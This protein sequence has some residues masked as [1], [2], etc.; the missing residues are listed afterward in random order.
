M[1]FRDDNAE[2]EAWLR[3]QCQVV[4]DDLAYKHE[5]MKKSAFIFLRATYFRWARCIET[6]CPA[7]KAAPRVLSVGD[8]HT[9]NY[10][11]WRDLEGRLV[12]GINDFDEAAIMP[13]PFDLVRLATSARLAE[14]MG[15][16]SREVA[17]VILESYRQGLMKPHPALLDE[18]QSWM[19]RYVAGT[20]EERADF[21]REV[22][23][24]PEATP[25]R[26][27][28]SALKSSLPP[29]ALLVRFASRRKGGGGLGRPRFVAVA[30]WRGGQI[31]R[32]AKALVPSAWDWAHGNNGGP[33]FLTIATGAYRAPDPHLA[34]K[35]GFIIRRIAPDSRKVDLG[36][37]PGERLKLDLL[38][39]MGFEIG[40]IHAATKGASARIL[41]DLGTRKADWLHGA[42]KVAAEAVEE[43]LADWR[44]AT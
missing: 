20:D 31:V 23:D 8:A 40:A 26:P 6:I 3:K 15:I 16:G 9:E 5:R 19:R 42:A 13:Y 32:E 29:G 18:H 25:P 22:K 2:F 35:A 1:R 44:A 10:G 41:A 24:Y 39:A 27:V 36:D 4:E 33:R 43:D 14:D 28:A 17:A 12:W 34:L 21:W 37:H 11:T 30:D 7:L 38:R